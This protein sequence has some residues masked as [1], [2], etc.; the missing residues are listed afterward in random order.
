[1]APTD[2]TYEFR[3]GQAELQR[4]HWVSAQD[5]L[6]RFLDLHPGHAV[7]DSA[8][9]LMGCAKFGARLYP[10]A[11]VEFQIV[12][13]EYPRSDLRVDA[14]FQ[15]CLSYAR[16]MRSPRLDPTPAMRARTCFDEFLL[17]ATTAA[18]TARTRAELRKIADF[19]AEKDYQIGKMYVGMKLPSSA[20]V[21]L[22]DV[23]QTY[24][25]TTRAADVWLQL[26]RVEEMENRWAEAAAAY[27]RV[28]QD[29]ADS[30]AAADARKRLERLIA[31]RP[32]LASTAGAPPPGP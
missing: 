14:A 11:A 27:R 6:K 12:G 22:E 25:E 4:E 8:Q 31:T 21:Y 7:A 1:M 10:E 15:E 20:R 19:L 28:T 5:H 2:P 3:V 24:P 30:P 13:Q 29:Y 23:L 26:G 18:D 9:Y 32:E 17:R 16:Q